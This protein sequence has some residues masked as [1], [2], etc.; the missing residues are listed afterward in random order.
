MLV[1]LYIEETIFIYRVLYIMHNIVYYILGILPYCI[2]AL[3]GVLYYQ[4]RQQKRLTPASDI[5]IATAS[6]LK[7]E[8]RVRTKT[9]QQTKQERVKKVK[10]MLSTLKL[11]DTYFCGNQASDYAIENGYLDYATLAKA[12]DAVLNNSIMEMTADIGYWE[13]ESGY[14][15][16]SDEIEE[17]ESK[18]EELEEL[19]TEDSTEEQDKETSAKIDEIREQIEELEEEQDEQPEIFQYFIVSDSGAE[20]LKD[21]NEIIFYN[22]DLDMYIWGVTHYGTSWSYVLTD[23]KLNCGNDAF[24]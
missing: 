15:D 5:S 23:V 24:N 11:A 10:K 3:Y 7:Q 14:I 1:L 20:I 18:I 9:N 12:F 8:S 16:N 2:S 22:S 6:E 13:Q 17:L 19:I 4:A 21:I